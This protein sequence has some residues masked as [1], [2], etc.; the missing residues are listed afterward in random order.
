MRQYKRILSI[1]VIALSAAIFISA[2]AKSSPNTPSYTTLPNYSQA[3]P[4]SFFFEEGNTNDF[5]A[6][7]ESPFILSSETPLSTFSLDVNTAAYSNIRRYILEGHTIDKNMVR[8]EEMVNYFRYNYPQPNAGEPLSV[9][10]TIS[11]CPWNEDAKLLT[12]GLKAEEIEM[13]DIDNNIVF[14]L[15]VSGSMQG[16]DKLGLMQSA[17]SL[18]VENLN[19]TDRISIVTYAGSNKILLE[20]ARGDERE[21]IIEIINN[22]TAGG[23]TAGANGI[24]S[25]YSIAQQYFIE[26]GNNRV[27]L[28]TDGDFNVGISSQTELTNLISAKRDTGIYLTVL[29]FGYG[30]LKDNKLEALANNGNGNYAYIDNINEARKV[31]VEEIGGTLKTV[32][33]DVK[34]QVEFNPAK[35]Y[36]YRLLGYENKLLTELEFD[37]P[38][39]DAGE[40]GAG[41]T[42]TAVYEIVLMDSQEISTMGDNYLSVNI[43]YKSPVLGEDDVLEM[44][45]YADETNITDTPDDDQLFISAVVEFALLLRDSE[46]KGTACYTDVFERLSEL[47]IDN[48]SYKTEF[49]MLV[50]KYYSDNN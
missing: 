47:D 38:L 35:V 7:I 48:D 16:P 1:I 11:P 19:D 21:D 34:A 28:A 9:S 20:G 12:V 4:S 18:L 6:I 39:K 23:S 2:C 8:T 13:S 50:L 40:I 32:A 36:N 45:V 3:N 31:L 49:M 41:H 25:A 26:G 15:D 10:T 17:F 46:Y 37:D 43:R 27:I 29:G 14:L 30:N 33:R 42:I 24:Q 5:N 44:K 22:L